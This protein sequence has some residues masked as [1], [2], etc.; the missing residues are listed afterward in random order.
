MWAADNSY[1]VAMNERVAMAAVASLAMVLAGCGADQEP[2][3]YAIENRNDFLVACARPLNDPRLLNDVC[4]CA[5]DRIEMEYSFD[6]F[7]EL[8]ARLTADRQADAAD[9][10]VSGADTS[11]PSDLPAEIIE[12]VADCFIEEADL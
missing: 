4:A 6:D 10:E 3:D 11:T 5:Y 12:I 1:H 9:L 7:V 2:T 8:D